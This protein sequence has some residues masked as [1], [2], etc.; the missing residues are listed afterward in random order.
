VSRKNAV[1]IVEVYERR[2]RK[3]TERRRIL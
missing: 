2:K 1:M 3:A